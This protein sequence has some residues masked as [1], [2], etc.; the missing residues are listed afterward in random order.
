MADSSWH[1]A[2]ET[3]Y[4]YD[5]MLAVQ[6]RNS[7]NTPS[8]TYTRGP[9]L[10]GTLQG[11]GGIGGLLARSGS[12]QSGGTWTNNLYCHANGNGNITHLIQTNQTAAATFTDRLSINPW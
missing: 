12:H 1:P 8:V 10:S 6:T 9:D 7:A 3:R 4:I 5:G 2:L 11:A